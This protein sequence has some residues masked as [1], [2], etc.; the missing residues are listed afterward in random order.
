MTTFEIEQ[1][2]FLIIIL[3]FLKL[4][5]YFINN[6]FGLYL[7]IMISRIKYCLN[8]HSN[9]SV[10]ITFF[11]LF[12]RALELVDLFFKFFIGNIFVLFVPF[13]EVL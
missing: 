12:N 1:S 11:N 4:W 10:F 2:Q 13:F 7:I 9:I 6:L 5:F 8:I 3:T